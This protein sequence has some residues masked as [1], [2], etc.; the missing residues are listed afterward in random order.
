MVHQLVYSTGCQT[1]PSVTYIG[2]GEIN[3][4]PPKYESKPKQCAPICPLCTKHHATALVHTY[5]TKILKI[6]EVSLFDLPP[7]NIL[8]IIN[9]CII[10]SSYK[11]KHKKIDSWFTFMKSPVFHTI[12]HNHQKPHHNYGLLQFYGMT[13]YEWSHRLDNTWTLG[14]YMKQLLIKNKHDWIH[15]YSH[16]MFTNILLYTILLDPCFS[17]Y[18]CSSQVDL[19]HLLKLFISTSANLC[20][21]YNTKKTGGC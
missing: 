7:M 19:Y 3:K 21:Y 4:P 10:S 13:R 9:Y 20:K 8:T 11:D 14:L 16:I 15:L 6:I 1:N 12:V 18:S 5:S 17:M 2:W